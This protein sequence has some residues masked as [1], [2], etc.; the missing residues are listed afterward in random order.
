MRRKYAHTYFERKGQGV[1]KY[2]F[3]FYTTQ[4]LN[5]PLMIVSR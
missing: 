2:D 5:T 1:K 4:N 3:D